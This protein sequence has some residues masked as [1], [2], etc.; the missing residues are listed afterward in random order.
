LDPVQ[1]DLESSVSRLILCSGK[2]YVDLATSE[3]FKSAKNLAVARIEQLYPFPSMG[4]TKILQR[5]PGL[6]QV[7][8]LQEEPA[9]QGPWTFM[10]P[11]LLETLAENIDLL[12]IG[13]AESASPAEGSLSRHKAQQERIIEEALSGIPEPKINRSSIGHAI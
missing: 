3:L 7:V 11:R 6:R 10:R 2:V 5:F 8:W 9:N 1:P 13:R 12:Y 4:L